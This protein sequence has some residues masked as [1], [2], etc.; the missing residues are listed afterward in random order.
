MI[1]LE[2]KRGESLLLSPPGYHRTPLSPPEAARFTELW[3]DREQQNLSQLSP[4]FRLPC[5]AGY[6]EFSARAT[7]FPTILQSGLTQH[8]WGFWLEMF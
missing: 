3:S 7:Y 6:Q 5:L 1:T 2:R 8:Q 4:L